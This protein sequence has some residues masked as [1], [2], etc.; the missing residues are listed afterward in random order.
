MITT[1]DVANIL[2]R[3]CKAFGLDVYQNG[4]IPVG[5]VK[6]ERITIHAKRQTAESYWN[7]GFVEV[8]L[9]VPDKNGMAD[10]ARL[11]ELEKYASSRF[12]SV[13]E[14]E[15]SHYRYSI[16]S[17]GLEEDTSMKC[18]YINVRLLFEV[19]NVN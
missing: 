18:H 8:N 13:G 4:A 19:L 11:N 14:Y 5:E 12:D 9:C 3:D 17:Y 6:K 10:L 15:N 16:H 7:K 1:T 2:Y